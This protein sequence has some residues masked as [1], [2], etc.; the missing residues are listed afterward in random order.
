MRSS[1]PFKFY[2]GIIAVPLLFIFLIWGVYWFEIRFGYDFTTAGVYPKTLSGLKGVIFSPFIHSSLRH[3]YNNTF[4]L[5]ILLSALL[6]FYSRISF[7]I[8]FYG[9]L[10]SGLLTWSF[11]REAYHIGASGLIYVLVSFI[12][13]KG[14]FTGYYRLIALSMIVVFLYGSL[15]WYIFPVDNTISWEGHLSGFITGLFL[16]IVFKQQ[17][18]E[19]KKY[20]WEETTFNEETDPFLQHFDE[21]GNFIPESE[22]LQRKRMEEK[23]KTD[24]E[25]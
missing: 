18:P 21:D 15:L 19:T 7:K 16:A 12:F 10:L 11:A 9:I 24:D 23:H 5:L 22:W 3:L 17:L 4:P 2:D 25:D 20:K 14:I 13:F 6:Y 1:E 8:I